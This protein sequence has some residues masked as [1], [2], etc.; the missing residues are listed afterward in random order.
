METVGDY[1]SRRARERLDRDAR[2]QEWDYRATALSA[3]E[4]AG[5]V[6]PGW[7]PIVRELHHNLRSL[8]PGYRLFQV[9]EKLGRLRFYAS[10]AGPFTGEC[11]R[12]VAAAATEA[13]RT[14]EVCGDRGRLRTR[15]PWLKTLCD[16]CWAADRAAAEEHGERYAA[17]VLSYFL[18]GDADH[19]TPDEVVE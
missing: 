9:K 4:L 18:T 3:N 17:I 13:A 15:R 14:C 7:R 11:Q 12:R 8:D 2:H 16:A 6:G 5:D 1:F 19:P 10:F